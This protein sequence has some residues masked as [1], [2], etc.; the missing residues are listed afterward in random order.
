[1]SAKKLL[2]N[3]SS[4]LAERAVFRT[5]DA[6]SF[7]AA[8][9]QR[10]ALTVLIAGFGL[11]SLLITYRIFFHPLSKLPGPFLAKFSG[12]WRNAKYF[13]G[14]WHDDVLE[15]HKKYGRV[16]RVAPNEVSI[17][18]EYAMK[19]LYGHGHNAQKTSWYNVWNPPGGRTHFFSTTDKK[20]HA[21]LRKRV[22]GAYSMSSILK[23]EQYIQSCLDLLFHRLQEHAG[24]GQAV[25]IAHFT[26]AFAFD[27]IGELGHGEELGHLRT[28][29]DVNG[30]RKDIFGTF[31]IASTMGHFPIFASL[32]RS[33]FT[34]ALLPE[35]F[36]ELVIWSNKKIADRLA[37][38]QD[39]KRDDML[40]H[41]CRMKTIDGKPVPADDILIEAVNLVGA[42]ADTTA[43]GMKACLYYLAKSP[44]YYRLVQDEVD[45]FHKKQQTPDAITYAQTQQLP[46]LQAVIKEATRLMPS[47]VFQLLRYAPE[48]FVVRDY[49]IPAGTPV[50]ISPIAQNRDREIWGEDADEFRPAR[51]LEDEEKRKYFESVNMTF[52]GNGPRTC[53]GKNIALVEIHK[54]I[55]QFIYNF[56]FAL[57]DPNDIWK[58][59]TYWFMYQYDFKMKISLRKNRAPRTP[60]GIDD[61]A[62]H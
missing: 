40:G 19:N 16:V 59:T 53:I 13:R 42:G 14:Q 30:V 23:Y 32:A 17:V 35:L 36:K 39:V 45:A 20:T 10:A 51:W 2:L 25:D 48:N 47:I 49:A 52:G 50:G 7:V 37:N 44:E 15:L 3:G 12:A 8:H 56:D 27:V 46:I 26:D 6:A 24:S 31:V 33:N 61:D 43:I 11:L 28:G 22:T 5:S 60:E 57:A 55:A 54:F 38:H 9:P 58:I 18:D 29:T 62:K 1:M 41:F 34:R 4:L 21:F